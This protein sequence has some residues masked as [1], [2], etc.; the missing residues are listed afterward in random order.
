MYSVVTE[1][2]MPTLGMVLAQ[3]V[4]DMYCV[5]IERRMPTLDMVLMQLVYVQCCDRKED[6]YPWNGTRAAGLCTVL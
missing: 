1:R 3:L 4:Y 6:A 2:R 5:V